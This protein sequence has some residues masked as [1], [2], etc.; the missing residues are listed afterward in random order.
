[1]E[2]CPL[3]VQGMK[4]KENAVKLGKSRKTRRYKG[5]HK[6]CHVMTPSTSNFSDCGGFINDRADWKLPSPC[7]KEEIRTKFALVGQGKQGNTKENANH[8]S[9][10]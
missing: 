3:P 5:R 10:P 1:M 2:N 6:S 8:K 7:E 9:R 4:R